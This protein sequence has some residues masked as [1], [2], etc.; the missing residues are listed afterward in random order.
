MSDRQLLVERLSSILE[1]LERIPRRFAGI[2]TPSDF[3]D[4]DAGLDRMDAICM[5]LIAVGE[6]FK[7]IDRKTEGKL[8][9]C[10]SEANWRGIMGLR[11]FLAHGYFQVNANQLFGI[12]RDDIPLLIETVRRMILELS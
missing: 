3:T 6:E 2:K 11:D 9:S 10:Y 4:T 7:A 1:A 12:C 5:V 8:L